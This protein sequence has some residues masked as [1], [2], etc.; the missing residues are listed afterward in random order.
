MGTSRKVKIFGM[1]DVGCV[2]KEN[3]DGFLIRR[4]GDS[5][6]G[7]NVS[8]PLEFDGGGDILAAVSDGMGG[9]DSG[10]IASRMSL[11]MLANRISEDETELADAK[12]GEIVAQL[13]K[14]LWAANQAILEKAKEL[15]A[16]KGMGA[17]MTAL[18]VKDD[19]MYLLQVGDSRAYVLRDG[20]L[21]R[22]TRDQSF[23]GHLVDMGAITELQAMRHP[24]RNVILQAMGAQP[25]LKIDVSYL[26]LCCGDVV[27]ACS[28]GLYSE[29]TPQ[30]F[31]ER[32]QT[33]LAERPLA[34]AVGLLVDEAKRAGGKDNITALALA[35]TEGLPERE[36]GEDPRYLAFPFLDRDNPF[37]D[38]RS[39]FQ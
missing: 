18:Y 25:Q 33:L 7:L 15:R 1:T 28:D 35:F 24:Q 39:L 29:F 12:P 31:E 10:E 20:R 16:A 11:T 22:I 17:T 34:E 27:L 13:E 19:V 32:V 14:A 38:A 5:E 8:R 37:E 36:P 21:A 6:G 3:E 9:A 26:P 30:K 2:R 23:V 4:I